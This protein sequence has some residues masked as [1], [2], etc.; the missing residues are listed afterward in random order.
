MLD[1]IQK[2]PKAELHLHLEGAI[3]PETLVEINPE[4]ALEEV[5]SRYQYATF[6]EF[7]QN[8]GWVARNLRTPAHYGIATRRLLERLEQQNVHYAEI[9]LAAGVVLG[10][11]GDLAAVHQAVCEAAATS[12]V[13]VHWIWDAV[14]QWGADA[15]LRVATMAGERAHD[16]VV[17]FG[18]GGDET[19]GPARDFASAFAHARDAGLRLVCH[20]GEWEGP[21]SVWQALACGAERIGH[22]IHSI[23]DPR[24][25]EHLATRRIPL[26][27]SVSSN[28]L[29][30]SIAQL[31][32]HPLRRLFDAG[33]PIVLNTDDP[34][35]FHTTL[36]DE[37]ALAASEF[38]FTQPELETVARNSFAYAFAWN[39]PY[40]SPVVA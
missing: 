1:V 36:V 13:E 40:P 22:G 10:K 23:R 24:L 6:L 29:T 18:L 4:L 5:R 39:K 17:A 37:Y 12:T 9:T 34:P 25:V 2:L 7:L 31:R 8:F 33:V 3:E 11:Q 35:M 21:D 15:A 19:N 28:V 30:G 14:R 38:G 32:E 16:G 26:E 20:A 27:I